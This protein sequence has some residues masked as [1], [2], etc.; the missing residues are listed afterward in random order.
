VIRPVLYPHGLYPAFG[1]IELFLL[2]LMTLLI[3]TAGNIIN[4]LYDRRIDETNKPGL[5]L[6]NRFNKVLLLSV[7]AVFNIIGIFIGFYLARQADFMIM[8]WL[9]L[10]IV[11]L[12]WLYSARYKRQFLLGNIIVS[13]LS[14]FVVVI[15]W[16]F[17]FLFYRSEYGV[18]SEQ[19]EDVIK[20]NEIIFF[21]ASFAFLISLIREI[22]KDIQDR[23]GDAEFHCNTIPVIIGVRKS[24]LVV[25]ILMSAVVLILVYLQYLQVNEGYF[26]FSL[27]FLI[28]VQLPLV[29]LIYRNIIANTKKEFHAVSTLLKII[30]VMGIISM[31]LL[32]FFG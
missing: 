11:V 16:L 21:Y 25:S 31:A 32:N 2:I 19:V 24:K 5:N 23:E 26:V 8:G 3:T 10:C 18:T 20:I 12:L 17:E 13:F 22:I 7:Y 27:Y 9:V 30:M 15:V 14:A 6:F 1:N 28:A 4:D 29:F